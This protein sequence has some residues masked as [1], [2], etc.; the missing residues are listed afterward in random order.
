MTRQVHR[1]IALYLFII[2]SCNFKP[3]FQCLR[4]LP[5]LLLCPC[6]NCSWQ[7]S[8]YLSLTPPHCHICTCTPPC[9]PPPH[10]WNIVRGTAF[11]ND[12]HKLL[13][14]GHSNQAGIVGTNVV[15]NVQAIRQFLQ[16]SVPQL[17]L[18]RYLQPPLPMLKRYH[19]III[20]S[21]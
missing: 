8:P 12:G 17:F 1:L 7:W 21:Y 16:F 5:C 11:N 6:L 18:L 4:Q 10:T 19:H 13:H 2:P 9:R 3:P 14:W 20:D 15:W